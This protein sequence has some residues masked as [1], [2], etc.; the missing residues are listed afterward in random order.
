MI[1]AGALLIVPN[2]PPISSSFAGV[3]GTNR[4]YVSALDTA[5]CTELRKVYTMQPV[6]R[7]TP[8]CRYMLS[9]RWL[10]LSVSSGTPSTYSV[11]SFAGHWSILAKVLSRSCR[12]SVWQNVPTRGRMIR[13]NAAEPTRPCA[14]TM[15]HCPDE[16]TSAGAMPGASTGAIQN[17]SSAWIVSVGTVGTGWVVNT[18]P[19]GLSWICSCG[20]LDAFIIGSDP[21][22]ELSSSSGTSVLQLKFP[23]VLIADQLG[24]ADSRLPNPSMPVWPLYM[25]IRWIPQPSLRMIG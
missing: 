6:G 7:A 16:P 24:S 23:P 3:V 10:K 2:V 12:I 1:C 25:L 11:R 20:W 5:V 19:A 18:V 9:A 22:P 14:L 17:G 15:V 8:N 21:Y 4:S 13:W